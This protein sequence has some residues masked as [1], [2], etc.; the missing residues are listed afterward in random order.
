MHTVTVT[1]R[2]TLSSETEERLMAAKANYEAADQFRVDYV[3][4]V[5]AAIHESSLRVVAEKTGLSTNTL[6]RWKR[7]AEK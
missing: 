1:Q 7:E 2:G 5:V 3:E 4:I 6:Q